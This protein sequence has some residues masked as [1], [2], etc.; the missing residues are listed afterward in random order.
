MKGKRAS[1]P[2]VLE[3]CVRFSGGTYI[4]RALGKQ[5]TSTA[6]GAAAV[7]ALARK[8]GY[9]PDLDVQLGEKADHQA[10]CFEVRT[11]VLP[12]ATKAAKK[13]IE[14]IDTARDDVLRGDR[15]DA[16]D[17]LSMAIKELQKSR[18]ITMHE[19]RRAIRKE[20]QR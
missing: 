7:G 2:A 13:A 3:G 16:I 9:G 17:S 10:F 5:A 19:S 15:L 8:L 14:W 11:L 20:A 1:R 12:A 18:L 4:A 6:S